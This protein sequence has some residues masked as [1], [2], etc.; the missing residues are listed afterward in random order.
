VHEDAAPAVLDPRVIDRFPDLLDGEGVLSD[1]ERRHLVLSTATV[2]PW[3]RP[4][5]R[6]PD[7]GDPAV[8]LY[9]DH[10]AVAHRHAAFGAETRIVDPVGQRGRL[11]LGDFIALPPFLSPIKQQAACQ[12]EREE[13][14]R[15]RLVR[16]RRFCAVM[17]RFRSLKTRSDTFQTFPAPFCRHEL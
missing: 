14:C 9:L 12:Q 7:A 4:R 2:S 11:H 10:D 8:G 17:R 15:F 5:K 16:E 6:P 3:D 1:D 13:A